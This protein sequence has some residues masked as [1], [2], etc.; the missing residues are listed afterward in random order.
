[1]E[2]FPESH[3][4]KLSSKLKLD[5]E[6]TKAY[7]KS[8]LETSRPVKEPKLKTF[9]WT[10]DNYDLLSNAIDIQQFKVKQTTILIYILG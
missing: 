4:F 3:Y 10:V 8:F 7:L 2:A 1:M 6:E 5:L 9:T